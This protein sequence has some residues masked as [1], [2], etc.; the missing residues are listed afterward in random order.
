MYILLLDWLMTLLLSTEAT[1][2]LHT[3]SWTT[4]LPLLLVLLLRVA[5]GACISW[6]LQ[7][8]LQAW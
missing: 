1:A 3:V 8:L 4:Q 5:A 6:P 2:A 7:Q